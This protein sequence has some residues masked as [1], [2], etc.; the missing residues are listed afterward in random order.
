MNFMK[1]AILSLLARDLEKLT[2]EIESYNNESEL[3]KLTG[4]ISN[5]PGTLCL[6]IIGNLN[7][8]IGS[9]L[10]DTGYVRNRDK[11]F[12]LK[13]VNRATLVHMIRDTREVVSEVLI[14]QDEGRLNETYPVQV[15]G[16]DMTTG[17]FLI[18]LCTH[19]NYH[20][21]QINY[22]RRILDLKITN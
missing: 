8:F 9:I 1:D 20:L 3:W 7:H 22:H 15:F 18:H 21:G 19:L 12:S 16:E 2:V 4:A 14:R 17:F 10:G 13:N 6:H 11:E 5:S